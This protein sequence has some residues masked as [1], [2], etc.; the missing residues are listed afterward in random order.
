MIEGVAAGPSNSIQ[1]TI[2]ARKSSGGEAT[3]KLDTISASDSKVQI[4]PTA[5]AGK[6]K[7]LMLDIKA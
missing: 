5:T 3:L 6:G 1:Q 2:S 7:G 4:E